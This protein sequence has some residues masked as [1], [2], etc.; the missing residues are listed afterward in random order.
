VSRG[1]VRRAGPDLG[2]GRHSGPAD[3]L[4]KC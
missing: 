1:R 4:R 3:E 2:G